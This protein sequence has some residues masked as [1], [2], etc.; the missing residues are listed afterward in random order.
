MSG[1]AHRT[2]SKQ[3]FATSYK[4]HISKAES[5]IISV[6]HLGKLSQQPADLHCKTVENTDIDIAIYEPLTLG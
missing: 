3:F 1:K 6:N 4:S 2:N 5:E